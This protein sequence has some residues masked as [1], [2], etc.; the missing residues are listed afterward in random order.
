MMT[1]LKDL[2]DIEFMFVRVIG[3]L[4]ISRNP[5]AMYALYDDFYAGVVLIISHSP[6]T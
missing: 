5:I 6:Q 2:M 4:S 1:F 3:F